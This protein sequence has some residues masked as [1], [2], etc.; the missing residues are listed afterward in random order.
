MLRCK[1]YMAATLSL[2]YQGRHEKHL[3]KKKKL[4]KILNRYFKVK[5]GPVVV[6]VKV[7]LNLHGV[8]ESQDNV[9]FLRHFQCVCVC[10]CVCGP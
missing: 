10:L 9:A 3:L 6:V 7:L 8:S 1:N 4:P 2:K 5:T